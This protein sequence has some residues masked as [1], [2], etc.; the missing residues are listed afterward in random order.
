MNLVPFSFVL[1]KKSREF[2]GLQLKTATAL[3]LYSIC[4]WTHTQQT[5]NMVIKGVTPFLQKSKICEWGLW[6]TQIC[7]LVY[8]LFFS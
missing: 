6:F 5:A 7:R 1:L 4:I 8:F 3:G 2:V